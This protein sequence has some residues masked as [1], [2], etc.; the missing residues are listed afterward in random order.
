MS[1]FG[2][3]RG[4]LLTRDEAWRIAVNIAKLPELL[5]SCC[6]ALDEHFRNRIRGMALSSRLPTAAS[7]TR[8]RNDRGG[9]R[10]LAG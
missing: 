3:R 6:T 9:N 8:R 10:R 7:P 5:R 4:Y 1:R 2:V